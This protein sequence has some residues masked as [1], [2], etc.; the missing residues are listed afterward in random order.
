M[1]DNKIIGSIA[2]YDGFFDEVFVIPEYQG[3]GL[4]LAIVKWALAL[5]LERNV[6]PSL[7]VVTK[8]EPAIK[9]YQGVGF[10]IAQTLEMNRLF[11]FNKEPDLRGPIGG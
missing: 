6:K 2:L 4:G 9:L 11:S 1:L 10:K 3:K 7:C 8:N 5:C